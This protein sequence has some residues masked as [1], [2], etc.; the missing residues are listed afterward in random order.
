MPNGVFS[1][2]NSGGIEVGQQLVK[3]PKAAGHLFLLI[4][5]TLAALLKMS[6]TGQK[7]RGSLDA[8]RQPTD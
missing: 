8:H 3:H 7:A 2:L 4:D 5:I 6:T 1:N